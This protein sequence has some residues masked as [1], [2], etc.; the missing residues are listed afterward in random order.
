MPLIITHANC[1]DG[2]TS[3][4]IFKRNYGNNATY[5]ELD[6]VDLN[7]SIHPLRASKIKKQ[8]N[9]LT[10]DE[11]VMADICLPFETID[12][13]LKRGNKVSIID[14][15]ASSIETIERL[16]KGNYGEAL[17]LHFDAS[18]R[19]SG[20]LL[21]WEF[22]NER[23]PIPT[24]VKLVSD[25]DVWAHQ[26]AETK[27]LYASLNEGARQPKDIGDE[28]Y[29]TYLSDESEVGRLIERGTGLLEAFEEEVRLWATQAVKIQWQG[30]CGYMVD[31]PAH[32]KS[33]L[34]NALAKKEGSTFGMVLTEKSDCL[35]VS[36]RSVAPHTVNDLAAAYGGG[37]HEQ[38]SACRVKTR[39]ELM[40][41][42]EVVEQAKTEAGLEHAKQRTKFDA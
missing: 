26:F 12:S 23:Q 39:E 35:Q 34:G 36:L 4:A 22:L 24:F 20:A 16:K 6:H 2:C 13:L 18:T 15:H 33:E 37:G 9:D 17:S 14:H 10:Q 5:L 30:R 7:E 19:A 38:A 8:L 42:I 29:E 27:K 25:G 11:V 32:L 31:A 1:T 21:S 3:K 28:V 40:Q 41:G